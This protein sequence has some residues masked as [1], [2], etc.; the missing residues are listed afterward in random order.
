MHARNAIKCHVTVAV[1]SKAWAA[2]FVL[3]SES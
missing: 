2:S 1:V 3:Q